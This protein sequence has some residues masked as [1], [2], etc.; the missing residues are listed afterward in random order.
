[1]LLASLKV[2]APTAD[3][4]EQFPLNV[5]AIQAL[6]GEEIDFTAPVTIIVGDNGSGKSTFLEG[7]AVA[8]RSIAV[9]TYDLDQDQ[10][11][12]S[13]QR[14]ARYLHLSWRKRS[15]RGFF[16]RAEDFFG[17]AL[18][19]NQLRIEAE[20][21]LREVEA[22]TTLSPLARA[23]ARQTH[24]RTIG[25]LR[26][27]YG[28]GLDHASHGESFLRLFQSRFVPNGLYLLDEPEAPLAPIRQ[29]SLLSLMRD[30][31]EQQQSQFVIVTHSP[32]IMAYPKAQLL[33]I[34][35]AG[36]QPIEY[37]AIEHVTLLRDFLNQPDRFLRHL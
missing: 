26:H 33:Q 8:A 4:R 1:M 18:R 14:L 17:Y 16:L 3:D 29:L 19:L 13:A 32:I 31:V 22:D 6:I 12:T 35:A 27:R 36:L 5:P 37:N 9:G 21:G 2:K 34:S 24:S 7:L 23:Q 20:A 30:A 25:E 15:G 10:S 11:L 28:E